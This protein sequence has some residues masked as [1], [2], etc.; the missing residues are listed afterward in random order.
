MGTDEGLLLA[1]NAK[2]W[3]VRPSSLVT[4]SDPAVAL[5]V[6]DAL[7][8]RLRQMEIE[9]QRTRPEADV[10]AAGQRYEGPSDW[11]VPLHDPGR[12]AARMR[13]FEA[14]LRREGKVH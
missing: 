6:D 14:K 4:I 2:V 9:A 13:D 11:G 3:R 12:Q 5:A 1:L 8:L 10:V 7:A